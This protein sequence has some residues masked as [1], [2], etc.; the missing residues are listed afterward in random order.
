MKR[1]FI[2]AFVL[3]LVESNSVAEDLMTISLDDAATLG[4]TIQT[5]LKTKTEGKGSVRVSTHHPTKIC[6]GEV[7][8]LD[9]ENAKLVF[10]AK[11]KSHLDGMAFL[12]MWAYVG[13]GQYFSKGMD[14]PIKGKSD[15]KS[16]QTPF[17][18]QKGENP[19]KVVLNLVISGT[20]TVW[21]DDVV[22]SKEP[23]DS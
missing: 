6:L 21:V 13:T 4:T 22:L 19:E 14:N 12:E 17:V 3:I 16:L 18:L 20:G 10:K 7:I 9:V 23:L 2:I 15:W 1:F 11:V 5:D 8:G